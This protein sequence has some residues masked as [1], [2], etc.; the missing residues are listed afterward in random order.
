MINTRETVSVTCGLVRS[1]LKG[2]FLRPR[3][4]RK[5]LVVSERGVERL[6]TTWTWKKN[7][8]RNTGFRTDHKN[9]VLWERLKT[10]KKGSFRLH[11]TWKTIM[12]LRKIKIWETKWL[13][14]EIGDDEWTT[15]EI[16]L[17]NNQNYQV[18]SKWHE[19]RESGQTT[20]SF[21][22]RWT[23]DPHLKSESVSVYLVVSRDRCY[24]L[25][26]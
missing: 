9:Q 19:R 11:V 21:N 2:L 23:R 13:R 24:K 17:V 12:Q 16:L 18:V 20:T 26:L 10:R 22:L 15:S 6:P 7:T 3:L 5:R 25:T 1:L 8:F 14:F 4:A